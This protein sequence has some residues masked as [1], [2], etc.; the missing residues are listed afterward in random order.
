MYETLVVSF[1]YQQNAARGIDPLLWFPLHPAGQMAVP[2]E[3][4]G[5][6]FMLM[7]DW[8]ESKDW[9][10]AIAWWDG[11]C[12]FCAGRNL[13]GPHIRHSLRECKRGGKKAIRGDFGEALSEDA[14]LP[15]SG[16]RRC[17]LPFP[18]CGGWTQDKAGKWELRRPGTHQCQYSPDLLQDTMIGIIGSGNSS[19]REVIQNI[20]E[21]YSIGEDLD[22]PFDE[23]TVACALSVTIT[24]EDY[25]VGSKMIQALWYI[26]DEI[27]KMNGST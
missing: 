4:D 10:R 2:T 16:C 9:A 3:E 23:E 5:D 22:D 12:G 13:K 21:E 8:E 14:I 25:V 27:W 20:A 11:K 18:I 1:Y 15:S 19:L 24:S 26:T 17:H 6:R 7:K